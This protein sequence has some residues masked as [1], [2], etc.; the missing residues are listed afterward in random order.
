M[1]CSD[2]QLLAHLDGELSL[3]ARRRVQRHLKSCWHCRA[4]FNSCES[5]IQRLTVAMDE[6]PCP[7]PEWNREAKQR[8]NWRLEEV[9]AGLV[10][11]P[12]RHNRRFIFPVA[13]AAVVVLLCLAGWRMGTGK[14]RPPLRAA[15]V[16]A[17]ASR[18]ERTLYLQPVQ[19]TFSVEIAEIRPARRTVNARLEI[20]SDH[21]SGKFAS[22]LS[23]PGGALKHAMWRPSADT[24]FVYRGAVSSGV[25][26]Q[27]PHREETMALESLA[28]YGLDPVQLEAAF[29]H[30]LE[31]RSWNAISFASDISQWTAEDG[32]MASAEG[33]RGADGTPMI[34]I[35]AQ[36]K[37]RKMVA[38][39]IVDVDSSSY[40]PRLQT[41]RFETPERAI[42]FRLA[43]TAI[44][45][46]RRTEIDSG[47]F[48]P[49][50][51]LERELGITRSALPKREAPS[52][53]S[54]NELSND[55]IEVDP[56]A[57]EA[58][59]V[60]HQAG[61]CVGEPVRVSEE[62]GD[63]RVTRIGN[64]AGS[65][66]SGLGL[67]YLL[68]ALSD[69]RRGQLV[70]PDTGGAQSAALRHAWEMKRLAEDFPARRI[71]NLPPDS[72]RMLDTMLRDHTAVVR[73]EIEGFGL[74]R[75]DV[76]TSGLQDL[77]WRSSTVKVFETLTH[78]SESLSR[79][80]PPSTS[81]EFSINA[82]DRRLDDIVS[83]FS[84]ESR[85]RDTAIKTK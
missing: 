71:A 16:I 64:E 52:T 18:A 36:R 1:H 7:P 23:E 85:R 57:V 82:I 29:V 66:K 37:S 83:A 68:G 51:G 27:A 2:E 79:D 30:W 84:A 54:T 78:L 20:W 47:V 60:L 50:P 31:S 40:R 49:D 8:L 14:I 4:R 45:P 41:I 39:L 26:K 80:H 17:E 62:A 70:P 58:R 55:G 22:R 44:Q 21:D 34:R 6:W 74:Q 72:W 42:E 33:M 56:R 13:A 48:Q 10:E 61:A 81:P 67:D 65:Y 28:D 73:R 5:E 12:E 38:I 59:F 46:I 19:Q 63:T 24:E 11:S 3:F 69:L 75:S 32:S 25:L 9:E 43:A 15:D 76:S 77:D 53:P 35:T